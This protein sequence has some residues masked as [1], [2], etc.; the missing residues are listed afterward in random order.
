MKIGIN[1]APP[2]DYN[3]A[4]F[5]NRILTGNP[6]LRVS[7]G[8]ATIGPDGWPVG[9]GI[10]SFNVNLDTLIGGPQDY[11]LIM[12][13]GTATSLD[14]NQ[15]ADNGG[16]TGGKWN[17]QTATFKANGRVN[18]S[19]PCA[20][21]LTSPGRARW[22]LCLTSELDAYKADP[23]AFS[24]TWFKRFAGF[25]AVRFMDWLMTNSN[26]GSGYVDPD[27]SRPGAFVYGVP[28]AVMVAFAKQDGIQPW[29]CIPIAS[30]DAAV[31]SFAQRI[32]ECR[33]AGLMPT[34]EL[35]NEVW[36][37]MF[38][39]HGYAVGQEIALA[40]TGK[41][42][43]VK[44]PDGSR[45]Y[46]YRVAQVSKILQ[47]MGWQVGKDFHMAIG[48][49]PNGWDR[50][51]LVWA[52]VAAAGGTDADFSRW[53]ITF[54][55]H[56]VVGADFDK[57]VAMV[58]AQDFDGAI[59]SAL[60]GAVSSVDWLA[61]TNLP[62]HAGIAKAHGLELAAY[63]GNM[64]F[65]AIPTFGNSKL[66]AMNTGVTQADVVA[67]F[68][69]LVAHPRSAE[70]MTAALNAMEKAG[71]TLACPYA[72]QGL[73]GENGFWGL[74]GTPAWGALMAWNAA[75][76]TATLT[77]DDRVTDIERRLKVAGI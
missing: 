50:A 32:N 10:V 27:S 31:I 20:I 15:G 76:A 73:G 8:A 74:Y 59:D 40:A 1:L 7:A 26:T 5:A 70:V 21:T 49:F 53:I 9:P 13:E 69:K 33:T 2:A 44:N 54:Y 63:E 19:L 56:G 75:K 46:G 22:A 16:H 72:D 11:T 60:H 39:A 58:K 37:L 47:S 52:G 17:G 3:P 77:L 67:F 4:Q 55:T 41:L 18:G 64:S 51:P 28:L 45:W 62:Q 34:I 48:C 29:F 30:D 43:V 24:P 57:T 42:A 25:R 65:Y 71:V 6:R 61:S 14:V 35:G 66:L 36:N 12:L 23:L 68:G 38:W